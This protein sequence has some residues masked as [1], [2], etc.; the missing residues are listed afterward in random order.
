MPTIQ[1]TRA[2]LFALHYALTEVFE[3]GDVLESL[4]P[5]ARTRA[6]AERAYEKVVASVRRE[7]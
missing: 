3:H 2:Q 1:F 5:D 6:A 7:R 4:F